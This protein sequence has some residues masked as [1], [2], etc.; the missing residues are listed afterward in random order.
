MRAN[1]GNF[2]CRRC[3]SFSEGVSITAFNYKMR[4][5]L[6]ESAHECVNEGKGSVSSCS[7]CPV[8]YMGRNYSS[9]GYDSGP[10]PVCIRCPAG[11]VTHAW[12]RNKVVNKFCP[13]IV[14]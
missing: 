5:I 4:N 9:L 8:G 7:P 12:S 14:I 13:S 6:A 1:V 11:W 3:L 2:V 10:K